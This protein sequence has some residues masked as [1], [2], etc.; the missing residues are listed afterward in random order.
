MTVPRPTLAV[1]TAWIL[2]ACYASTIR[3][4]IAQWSTDEDM[5]HGF[6]V[7]VVVVWIV[8]RERERWMQ[9]KPEPSWWGLA[10]LV[11]A[12]GLHAMASVGVGLFAASV[13]LLIS[14][15]G[16]VIGLGGFRYVRAWA[17]PLLLTLFM[18]PKLA[19]VYN[20]VTLPLQLIASRLAAGI[21]SA[22]GAG[23]IR[24]GNILEVAGRR[25]WVAEACSGIRYLLPLAFMALLF[26]YLSGSKFWTKLAVL[27]IS[28]PLAIMANAIRVAAA[29]RVPALEEGTAHALAGWVIFVFCLAGLLLA[30]HLIDKL[31]ARYSA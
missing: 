1:L 2:L 25:I 20:Q 31:Y 12:A 10:I 30:R 4:M 15:V 21:L 7:P 26:T 28:V 18:L 29:A 24:E 19:V 13:A 16:A 22:M 11:G 5:G 23:V 8:W 3:S 6:L 14:A 9:L 27:A 17:F